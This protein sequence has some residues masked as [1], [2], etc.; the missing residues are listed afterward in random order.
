[1]KKKY[2]ILFFL[3]LCSLLQGWEF[4][5]PNEKSI[6]TLLRSPHRISIGPEFYYL[7]RQREGEHTQGGW[8]IGENMVY[9][10][11]VPFG[12]Y[13]GAEQY[14]AAGC[15]SAK[16]GCGGNL[17]SKLIDAEAE[18]RLGYTFYNDYLC[19]FT[20]TPFVGW[21]DFHGTNKFRNPRA[22]KHIRFRPSYQYTTIGFLSA[23]YLCDGTTTFGIN[24][25]LKFM[26]KAQNIIEDHARR[27][28]DSRHHH[29]CKSCDFLCYLQEMGNKTL[30]QIDFP[31]TYHCWGCR[32]QSYDFSIIP[33]FR[34]R[35]Y[36]AKANC[37]FDFLETTIRMWGARVLITYLF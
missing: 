11:L 5:Y 37:P 34:N 36:G 17:I 14:Y 19:T 20:L 22:I 7:E 13:Y 35:K 10:R 6:C 9:E 18:G 21:G 26:H 24:I 1:M 4:Y 25:K 3:C 33:F 12:I 16:F 31:L 8:M 23:L 2:F 30:Y 28:P 32:E 15:V 29:H 27:C